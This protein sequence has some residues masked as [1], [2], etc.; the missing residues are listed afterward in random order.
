[1]EGTEWDQVERRAENEQGQ[2]VQEAKG[3]TGR[4]LEEGWP[5][6]F[7]GDIYEGLI[8]N[9]L[10]LD[11]LIC[12]GKK[13]TLKFQNFRQTQFYSGAMIAGR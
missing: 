6:F 11:T 13:I 3:Q 2:S 1:L 12:Y 7:S 5:D 9:F 4:A 8:W 10:F